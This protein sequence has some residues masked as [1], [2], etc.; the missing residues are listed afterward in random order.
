MLKNYTIAKNI[1]EKILEINHDDIY[2]NKGLGL[3]L[4]KLGE[5]EKGIQYLKNAVQLTDYKLYGTLS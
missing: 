4:C 5:V 2:A 1:N 3:T